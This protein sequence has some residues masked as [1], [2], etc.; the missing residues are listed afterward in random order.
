MHLEQVF[1][2]LYGNKHGYIKRLD[3]KEFEKRLGELDFLDNYFRVEFNGLENIPEK[4]GALIVGNHGPFGAD[5]PF[6]LKHVYEER[7]RVVRA[8]A[9]RAVFKI[10]FYRLYA[11][12]MGIV[13]GEPNQAV[14]LLK[15]GNLVSVYPGGLRETIKRPGQKYQIRPFWGKALGF[16][17]VALRAGVPIIPIACIGI[18]DIVMQLRT[19]EEMKDSFFARQWQKTMNHDKYTTPLWM[20]LGP[21]PLP[22]PVKLT[23]YVGWPIHL[24]YGPEAA[25]NP[26]VLK[27]LQERVVTELE[28]LIQYGLS[29]RQRSRDRI[30]KA[31]GMGGRRFLKQA[32]IV[33][34]QILK[35]T[36]Q[37]AQAA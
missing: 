20:G 28:S 13:E 1:P 9:D 15:E 11:T 2:A 34:R 27:S 36:E 30:L 31:F 29:E 14:D 33:G 7:G 35:A 8:L 32:Q 26:E 23:Y 3:H 25:E 37:F 16:V 5:A 21:L 17:R 4:D 22:I 18:D 12:T 6:V 24:G 10:P 19:A